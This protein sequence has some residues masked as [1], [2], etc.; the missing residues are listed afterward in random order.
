M[1]CSEGCEVIGG[2]MTCSEGCAADAPRRASSV[3][4]L[5]PVL[6]GCRGS[7]QREG[8]VGRRWAAVCEMRVAALSDQFPI[9]IAWCV[10]LERQEGGQVSSVYHT[11]GKS[12]AALSDQCNHSPHTY[13]T[14]FT[15]LKTG[16]A[17]A[18]TSVYH[19]Y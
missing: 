6:A 12:V 19:T 9:H 7:C 4:V 8:A 14:V 18:S 5:L 17:T 10:L 2:V 11:W 13:C 15:T 1:T 3:P 16:G